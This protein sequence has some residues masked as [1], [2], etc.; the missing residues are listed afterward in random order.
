MWAPATHSTRYVSEHG[1][2]DS[3]IGA[4][5]E[6]G[7]PVSS[8]IS[9]NAELVPKIFDDL[10]VG[11]H[12]TLQSIAGY[13]TLFGGG[14][15]GGLQTFEYGFVFGYSC[16]GFGGSAR[17][18]ELLLPGVREFIPMFELDGERELNKADP[19]HNSLL[20]DA[21]FRVDLKSIAGVQPRLGLGFVF[22]IDEGARK[23]LHW[24]VITSLVFE[25]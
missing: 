10:K 20:G 13:S 24:G 1:F 16:R 8:V 9:K 19:G 14:E 12:C 3:T 17:Q 6:A 18:K 22:P 5:M 11:D 21:A 4:G 25:Y 2:I 23:E 15:E 7:I